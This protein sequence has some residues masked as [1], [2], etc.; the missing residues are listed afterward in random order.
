MILMGMKKRASQESWD[1]QWEIGGGNSRQ[2]EQSARHQH[3]EMFWI[4]GKED[5]WIQ[6]QRDET[7][8]QEWGAGHAAERIDVGQ[9]GPNKWST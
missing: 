6:E 3:V 8:M 5:I 7:K 4:A 9:Q 2:R 1:T